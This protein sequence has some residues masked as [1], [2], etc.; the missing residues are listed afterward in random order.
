MKNR[1]IPAAVMLTAGLTCSLFSI[2]KK[3]DIMYSL[4]LLLFVLLIFY[5][6][7]KIAAR[8]ISGMQAENAAQ[9]KKKAE[10]ERALK[11]A[12]EKEKAESEEESKK[13]ETE[14]ENNA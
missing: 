2:I 4:V 13:E 3:W 8:I 14:T 10:E 5:C 12:E 7:G 6:I 1:Y 11:E 9:R